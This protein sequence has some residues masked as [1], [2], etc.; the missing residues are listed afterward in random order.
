MILIKTLFSTPS[1][2]GNG[3]DTLLNELIHHGVAILTTLPRVLGFI[4]IWT[5]N[6]DQLS[7]SKRARLIL[8]NYAVVRLQL[9][10]KGK[11]SRIPLSPGEVYSHR[12]D[13]H[14]RDKHQGTV[15]S[16]KAFPIFTQLQTSVGHNHSRGGKM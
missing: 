13:D 8:D 7:F 10:C 6:I 4:A 14:P 2:R 3:D 5:I 12:C 16:V 11:I 1:L 15:Q 9:S